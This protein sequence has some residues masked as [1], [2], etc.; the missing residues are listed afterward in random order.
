M[1]NAIS[2]YQC[3]LM[4]GS[5]STTVTYSKLIDIKNF[6][7]L[8]SDPE[9]IDVTTLSDSFRQY[10]LGIQDT[11]VL[12]FDYNYTSANWT[13]VSAACDGTTKKFAIWFGSTGTE[14]KFEFEGEASQYVS[15]GGVNEAVTGHISIAL[16]SAITKASGT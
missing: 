5:G 15:G 16:S 2:T 1:A 13:T 4:L 8:G 11:G 9:M 12:G 6:P 3:Q 14:G 10:I 7:D